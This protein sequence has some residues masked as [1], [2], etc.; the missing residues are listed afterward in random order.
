MAED[1]SDLRISAFECDIL[2]TAFKKSVI[3]GSIPEY[4]WQSHAMLLV[5]ELTDREHVEPEVLDWIVRK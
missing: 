4:R 2:R 3:E 1:H 5:H